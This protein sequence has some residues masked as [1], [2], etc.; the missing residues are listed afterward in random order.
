MSSTLERIKN[1]SPGEWINFIC[2]CASITLAVVGFVLPPKG[3]IDNS[4]LICIGELG[5]FSTISKIPDFIKELKNGGSVEV[6]SKNGYV[7]VEGAD[8]QENNK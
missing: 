7:K 1:A 4:V 5:L 3:Q 2:F 6:G 8:Q